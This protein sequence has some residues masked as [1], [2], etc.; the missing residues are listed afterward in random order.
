MRVKLKVTRYDLTVQAVIKTVLE[1]QL[2]DSH[3][4]Y[5][6]SMQLF[7]E[8]GTLYNT[9]VSPPVTQPLLLQPTGTC[10]IFLIV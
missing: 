1:T 4:S 3:C 9:E 2:D 10:D 6:E 8:H 5:V 7:G